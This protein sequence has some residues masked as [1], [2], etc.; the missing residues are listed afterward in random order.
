MEQGKNAS[1][2]DGS[3]ARAK[4]SNGSSDKTTSLTGITGSQP[5]LK[6]LSDSSDVDPAKIGRYRIIR[7]LGQGGFGRVYLAHDDDLD[8]AVAIKVPNPDRITLPEDLQAF[9]TEA[10]VLAK[11]DHPHIVPVHDVGRTEA[12]LCFVVSKLIEGSDLAARMDHARPSFRESAELVATIADALHYAHTRGLV[13][14][15]VKPANI[16]IDASGKPCVADF[17]L[18]LQD[19]DFGKG[20][21]LAGTPAYMSPEQARGEGHRVDGRSDIFSLGVVFYEL[22]TGKRPFRGDS[23]LNLIQAIIVDEPR[24]P[25]QIDDTIPKEL[26][27]IC[28]KALAK[29][30]SERY[31]TAKDMAEDLRVFLQATGVAASP[32]AASVPI[33]GPPASTLEDAPLPATSRQ[34]DSGHRPVKIVPRGL[35]SFD[36]HDA[37]F[38]LELLPGPRDRDGL[39]DSI[40]FWK[41]KIE[42]VDPDLTFKVGLI[43]G[44]SGCGKSSLMKAGLLPRLGKHVLPVYIEATPEETEARLLR[45]LR[46][47]CPELPRELAL[48]D[49]LTSLRRG[50]VLPPERKVVLVLDQFEQWLHA[51]RSEEN[52]E[53]V[54]AL[55]QCDGEHVQAVVMVRDDFWLAASRFMRD[56]EIRLLEGE[57]SALVDL[58]DPRHATKVLRAF[59]RAYGALPDAVGN[60]TGDQESFLNQS[61]SGLA[62][63]GK[64]IS[65]RLALFAEMVRGKPWTPA[66]LKDLGGTEGIGLTFLEET[67]SAPTAPPEHRLHQKAAQRVLRA[68]LPDSGTDIKGQ[69]RSRQELLE[70][71]GYANRPR[72][73]DDLIHILDPELRLITPTDPEGSGSENQATLP[74]GQYYQLAHDYL[75]HSLRDWLTRKQRETRRG[76][77]ELR[78][79]ERSAMWNAK[80]ENRHLPSALEWANI[81]LLT[82]KKGWTEPQRKMMKRAARLHGFRSVTMLALLC[83]GVFAAIAVRSRVV[84]NQ[85]AT[86]AAGLVERLLD[87]DT[88]QVPDIVTAMREYRQ[89]VDPALRSELIKSSDDSRQ[90][91]HASLALL[92]VDAGQ[93]GYLFNRLK[94]ATPDELPVLRDALNAQS[95]KLAPQLWTVLESAKP[96]DASLLPAASALANY[97]PDDGKWDATGGKVAQAL[98]SVDAILLGPWIEALRPVRARLTV[99]LAT[100]L[101]DKGR[102]ESEHKLATNILA[103]YASD[104]PNRLAELL[105]VADPKAYASLFPV[106]EKRAEQVLPVLQAELAKSATYSWND[107]PVDPSWPKPEASLV[108]QIELAEGILAERFAF[109]QTML[110][111]EFLATSE[112]LRKSGYRPVRFRPYADGTGT[113]VAAVWNRDGRNWRLASGQSPD[114]I[115]QQDGKNRTGKFLPVD[116]AGYVTS[117]GGQP[118]ER[119]AALWA[120]KTGDD[121][122]RLYLGATDDDLTEAQKPLDD[123][124]LI[125]R[126]L[127][128]VRCPDG[129]VRYSGVWGKPPS[130]GVSTEGYHDLFARD[131]AEDQAL[132]SD[133]VLVDVAI[134]EAGKRLSVAEQTREALQWA[135]KTLQT[136]PDDMSALS[137]RAQALLR[138]GENDKALVALNSVLAKS[139]D[140]SSALGLRAIAQARLGKKE[141]ALADLAQYHKDVQD[142]SG[143]YLAAVVAAELG[144]GADAALEAMEAA[145]KKEPADA[146]LRFDAARA[147]AVASKAID[148]S[149]HAKARSLAARSLALLEDGVRDNDLSFALLD[150]A[151]D[152]DPLRDDPAFA[153]LIEAGHPERR[154]AGVWSTEARFEAASVN[155]L[156][157]TE[158]LR[159]ARELATQGYRPIAWSVVRT[160][161]EGPPLSASVWHRPL[162]PTS[163]K[164]RLAERQARAAVALVRLG[165]AESVW[166]LLRHSADPRL[167]SF[168]LNWLNPLGADAYAVV[169]E[170]ER[171]DRA[172]SGSSAP[173]TTMDAILFHPETS[174]RRALILALGTYGPDGL[175]HG[176]REPLAPRLLVVYRDDPDAGVHG[177]AAWTLRQWGLK[178]KLIAADAELGKLKAP[179]GRRWYVNGQGQTF[180]VIAGPVE[181][182]MGS[183]ADEPERAGGDNDQAPHRMTIPRSYAIAATEVTIPQFQK[184]LK[185]SSISIPRYN[186][187]ASTL[188]KYSTDP[189]GPWIAPDWYT[190]AHYCNWLSEQEGLP[191]DQWCYEPAKEGGYAEGMTIPADVL[192]RR[193]YRLPTNA[194]W[195][196]ACRSCTITIR[197][198]GASTELLPL[199]A[200]FQFNSREHAG[201]CGSLLPNDLGLFDMLA[202]VYEWVNDRFGVSRPGRHSN[203]IDSINVIEVVNEKLPR[204]L[205]GGSFNYRP[206]YIRSADRNKDFP[207]YRNAFYGFRP[208]R[209]YP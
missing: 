138:L 1:E 139:R 50:R 53:L 36:E 156:D 101:Q 41:R 154:F 149:D 112:A 143:L 79:A 5:P 161:P 194:E 178:E 97:A 125:P 148:R 191:R 166:P 4:S 168:I 27:R 157:P 117:V 144:D 114:E 7:R 196:Y 160:S 130:A 46:K 86:Q 175:S 103:N 192:L 172:G 78:L 61:I 58:F 73:F 77:A 106:A 108:S 190:A 115:R 20:G 141:P 3:D 185:T 201:S 87:A 132:F 71:S 67:F 171:M 6:S 170:L 31:S 98:V 147:F 91:L 55:R 158:N 128:A 127:Q 28:Q 16:L 69:M 76:R 17:G 137:A 74:S 30:A 122:A 133:R 100:I 186:L 198:Y 188:A 29:R 52:T 80:A 179:G 181:F 13:H 39:P 162:I 180:A 164:D 66:A 111:D 26:E 140:D 75:V 208:A 155:A 104:D 109:C 123:A 200:R 94:K 176:E 204:L 12:G 119:Y 189:D 207:S 19:E 134:G 152:L 163:A 110:L 99:P 33:S 43:Y 51:R 95:T 177:A 203:T 82:G 56:V 49:S 173:N 34:S 25:R 136:K 151:P 15:D 89:A 22:I 150:D 113:R 183:P 57:N 126:T 96:G 124:K 47:V 197:Y 14:R 42:Q 135:E 37:D 165:R 92:P 131:F 21:G 68:L 121:D 199:Y 142:R 63:D 45:G 64:I 2:T 206:A 118:A 85:R 83:A 182:R 10:K 90:K 60:L 32:G 193:G 40:Q 102:L 44:P 105:M 120:E 9:L 116:V 167:R 84:E 93:V 129:R 195:E 62:Q 35:R 146:V 54:A 202:N 169:A 38:F 107:A 205:R 70:A 184:F 153:R 145:L 11:L 159:R 81:R 209:T 174:E 88:V 18:A 23:L 187:N 72:D 59:G 24:P 48:V 65:V 8:R